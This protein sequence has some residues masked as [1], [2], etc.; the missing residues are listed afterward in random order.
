MII[1]STLTTLSFNLANVNLK[2]LEQMDLVMRPTAAPTTYEDS[3]EQMDL[4]IYLTTDPTTYDDSVKPMDLPTN[5]TSVRTTY[6]DSVNTDDP[7][8]KL[9][10]C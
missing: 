7:Y 10:E 9:G 6:D 1:A 8:F 2:C 4:V 3:V 5:P